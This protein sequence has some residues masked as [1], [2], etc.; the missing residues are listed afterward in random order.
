MFFLSCSTCMTLKLSGVAKTSLK[1][2]FH[3]VFID[4]RKTQQL[5]HNHT[6]AGCWAVAVAGRGINIHVAKKWLENCALVSRLGFFFLVF[7]LF[8]FGYSVK[9]KSWIDFNCYR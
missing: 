1:A 8:L 3:F 9:I 2:I 5:G 4:H 7:S 6:F